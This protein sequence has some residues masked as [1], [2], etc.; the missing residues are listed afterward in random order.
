MHTFLIAAISQDGYIAEKVDQTSTDWTSPE[1]AKFFRQRTKEAGVMVMG[2][3]TFETIGRPLPGRVNI[4][5]SRSREISGL[6]REQRVELL[7]SETKT[8]DNSILYLTK[9][10]PLQLVKTLEQLGYD[11][12]AVCGGASVYRQ[13][14]E[15][16]LLDSLYLTIEPVTFKS[17]VSL[18][19]EDIDLNEL[20]KIPEQL[21]LGE[22]KYTLKNQSSLNEKG[23]VLVEYRLL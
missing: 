5:M 4:V 10:Q 11:E 2:R 16:G 6:K 17:G 7:D 9:L 12:L 23:T 20:S 15:S 1:D 13:F 18:F 14:L 8:L 19:G 3:A 22:V 21:E